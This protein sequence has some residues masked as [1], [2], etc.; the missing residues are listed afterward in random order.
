MGCSSCGTKDGGGCSPAGCKSNGTCNTGGCNSLNTKDWFRDIDMPSGYQTYGIVEIRFGGGRKEYYHNPNEL[1]LYIGDYLCVDSSVG[2]DIG[3]VSATGE[4]VRLQVKKKNL[5]RPGVELGSIIRKASEPEMDKYWE[6]KER[7]KATLE[8]A[9]TLCLQ[10]GLKM[11]L[12]DIDL[13]GDGRKVTFFY[14]AKDRVD[15]RELIRKF[16]DEFKLKIEM[17]HVSYREEAS[18]LGGIG[19]CGRTLCCSTWLTDYKLISNYAIRIQNLSLNM[20]KLNGQCGRLKCCLNFELDTYLEAVSEFPKHKITRIDTEDGVA[21]SKKTD[22]LKREMWFAYDKSQSWVPMPLEKVNEMLALNKEGKK[23]PSLLTLREEL[24]SQRAEAKLDEM[25]VSDMLDIEDML[26]DDIEFDKP[27]EKKPNNRNKNNNRKKNSRY[28]GNKGE[29]RDGAPKA[30]GDRKPRE[31][32]DNTNKPREEGANN[33]PK[34]KPR[35]NRNK[36]RGGDNDNK[37]E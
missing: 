18:R 6:C 29:S 37:A 20:E 16:A 22:I 25:E 12:S 19:V 11:K 13:Q 7:E 33:R 8:R 21:S 28:K 3:T 24:D 30:E 32:V 15:F 26:K 5:M 35:P 27:L 14:T 34:R 23:A 17:K 1:D 36:P 4:I 10:L 9:R 2:F 31:G